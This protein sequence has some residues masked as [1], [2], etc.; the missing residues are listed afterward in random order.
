MSVGRAY[1][2][3]EQHA[4]IPRSGLNERFL[5]RKQASKASSSANFTDIL[6]YIQKLSWSDPAGCWTRWIRP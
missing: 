3:I 1:K 4:V 2:P 5:L 6:F